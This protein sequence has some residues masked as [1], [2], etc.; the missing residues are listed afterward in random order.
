MNLDSSLELEHAMIIRTLYN[1]L[2]GACVDFC[3]V[4]LLERRYMGVLSD[5]TSCIFLE[6]WTMTT[7]KIPHHLIRYIKYVS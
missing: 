3:F 7:M 4:V 2:T 5:K 1:Q 6:I